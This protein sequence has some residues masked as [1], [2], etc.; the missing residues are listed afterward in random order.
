MGPFELKEIMI[1]NEL[2]MARPTD[3]SSEDLEDE[4]TIPIAYETSCPSCGQ[5]MLFS[6]IEI[7]ERKGRPDFVICKACGVVP[8]SEKELRS[9]SQVEISGT[10]LG[11]PKGKRTASTI[12]IHGEEIKKY[13]SDQESGVT[14]HREGKRREL[15][16]QGSIDD[17]DCPFQDP[18]EAGELKPA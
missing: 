16:G 5:L 14:V 10:K 8:S 6:I 13:T 18:V 17:N 15:V 9:A 3:W 7:I 4:A 12:M 1:G 11:S 2:L